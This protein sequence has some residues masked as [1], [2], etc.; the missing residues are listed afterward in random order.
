MTLAIVKTPLAGNGKGIK[1]LS[2]DLVKIN[3]GYYIS[4]NKDNSEYYFSLGNLFFD[5]KKPNT[6]FHPDWFFIEKY[7]TKIE[8]LVSGNLI[9]KRYV[10]RDEYLSFASDKFPKSFTLGEAT[11]CSTADDQDEDVVWLSEYE[12]IKS[13]YSFAFDKEED[14]LEEIVMFSI[15]NEVELESDFISAP[16]KFS[17]PTSK[18]TAFYNF[19]IT[20]KDLEHQTIDKILFPSLVLHEMP[21]SLSSKKVY[22]ILRQY[23][24]ENIDLKYAKITSNYDFCFSVE[25]NIYLSKPYE[26]ESEIFKNNGNS[27][28]PKQYRKS[29]INK[30]PVKIFEMTNKEDN[31]KG[32][33]AI[34]GIIASSENEMYEK[35]VKLCQDTIA[36]INRPLVDCDKCNGMGVIFEDGMSSL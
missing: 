22:S 34:D 10:L 7:P 33:T 21:C 1:M 17:F 27:Y 16:N 5:G 8:K 23:I 11:S 2:F 26:V 4:K 19:A 13:F 36:M 6:T 24:V 3:S 25:K 28:R 32:Y 12:R 29:Y 35:I 30:R 18:G 9:N 20:N 15:G 14:H 31:Y